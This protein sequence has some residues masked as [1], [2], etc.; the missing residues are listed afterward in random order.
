MVSLF[1]R[2]LQA[3]NPLDNVSMLA[4]A[5]IDLDDWRWVWRWLWNMWLLICNGDHGQDDKRRN[6]KQNEEGEDVSHGL[7]HISPIAQR[8]HPRMQPAIRPKVK[9]SIMLSP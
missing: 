1:F 4:D 2:F 5:I 7:P 8:Q 6:S 3:S 9:S